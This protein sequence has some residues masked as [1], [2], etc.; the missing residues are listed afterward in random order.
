MAAIDTA[1]SP[2][3]LS[4]LTAPIR[5]MQRQVRRRR[6]PL[7]VAL[8]DFLGESAQPGDKVLVLGEDS[9]TAA[10]FLDRGAFV[11]LVADAGSADR[12]ESICQ[13]RGCSASR[14]RLFPSVGAS[15]TSG[16]VDS[17]WLAKTASLAVLAAHYRHAKSRIRCGGTLFLDG[18]ASAH[19]KTLFDQMSN[20][21]AWRLDEVIAG[22]V[23][24]FRRTAG[25]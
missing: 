9:A 11:N 19:G 7:E 17:V 25:F 1:Q 10:A 2:S 13:L 22:D 16:E 23:A 6:G 15:I 20:D 8:E 18:L 21:M 3:F 5:K 4:R 12:V 14:L 24:V